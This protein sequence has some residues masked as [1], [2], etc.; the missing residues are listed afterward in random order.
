MFPAFSGAVVFAPYQIQCQRGLVAPYGICTDKTRI[1]FWAKDGI[2][3]HSGGP[4]TSLTDLDLYLLF[5][6]EGTDTPKNIVRNGVTYYAPDYSRAA[7]FR[8]TWI[9]DFLY[10]DYQDSTGTPRTL[11]CFLKTGAWVQDQY[12]NSIVSRCAL[13]QPEGTLTSAP[14]LY[15]LAIMA[16][17]Q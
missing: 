4:Y 2:G 5:P 8:L 17:N 11:V 3:F 6:H 1:F 13:V 12:A 15:D 9:N 14:A 16:D 10:A 7:T